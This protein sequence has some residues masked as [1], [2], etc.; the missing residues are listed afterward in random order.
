MG[1]GRILV[2]CKGVLWSSM[3]DV[4]SPTLFIPSLASTMLLYSP[5]RLFHL[6]TIRRA[7]ACRCVVESEIINGR[8]CGTPCGP[9][10]PWDSGPFGGPMCCPQGTRLFHTLQPIFSPTFQIG[11][12]I[13]PAQTLPP[14]HPLPQLVMSSTIIRRD[15]MK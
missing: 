15:V 11:P 5:L 8:V 1:G 9:G 13:F 14:R 10:D 12:S 6:K 7:V 4:P 2:C 3:M